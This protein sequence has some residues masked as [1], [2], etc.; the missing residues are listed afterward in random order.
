[1]GKL[2]LVVKEFKSIPSVIL[3]P[4]YTGLGLGHEGVRGGA[5]YW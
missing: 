5:V 1:M 2:E 4:G 3:L